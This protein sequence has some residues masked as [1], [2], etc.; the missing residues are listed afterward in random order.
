MRQPGTTPLDSSL[1]ARL[2]AASSAARWELSREAFDAAIAAS[3]SHRFAGQTLERAEVERYVE[4]LHTED[5]ALAAACGA[6]LE[7]AWEHFIAEYRPILYRSADAIDR[8]GN[9]RDMADSLFADLYGL[10]ERQGQRRSLFRYFHGRSRLATWLRAVISQRHID[11]LRATRKLDPL[12]DDTELLPA[13]SNGALPNADLARHQ[14]AVRAA[15]TAAVAELPPRDRLRLS[16]Y[17]VQDMTLAAIGRM[18][19]EHEATVSR[20]LTRT[21]AVLREAVEA[22]L[23]TDHGMDEAAIAECFRTVM[24]DAG[25]MNL[26]DLVG[27]P[28]GRK[29]ALADRSRE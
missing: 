27:T 4:S 8:T 28:P 26:A 2:Y 29:N 22:R 1:L 5:L 6:G 7:R 19:K 11:R 3:V 16:C 15:M 14:E 23:R 13:H 10:E 21:R 20:H 24:T 25:T 9:G 12:P 17:Y 18:L